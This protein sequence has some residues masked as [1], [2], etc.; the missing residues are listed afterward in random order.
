M[1]KV[2]YI[3]VEFI[4]DEWIVRKETSYRPI[5]VHRT[6]RAAIEAGREIARSQ[7]GQVVIHGKNQRIRKR[8]SYTVGPYNP[9]PPEVLFP[10]FRASRSKKAIMEAVVAAMRELETKPKSRGRAANTIK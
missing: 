7:Q 6:Q 3:H 9:Q 2:K 1:A 4:N 5:S 8:I 10:S